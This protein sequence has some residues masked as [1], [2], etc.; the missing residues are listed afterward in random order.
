MWRQRVR[1]VRLDHTGRHRDVGQRQCGRARTDRAGGRGAV[2]RDCGPMRPTAADV[3]VVLG[4]G[5]V[6]RGRRGVRV[7]EAWPLAAAVRI[8]GRRPVLHQRGRHAAAV[9]RPV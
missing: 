8:A 2:R 6:S 9:H 1:S 7:R 5:R 4:H 3:Y